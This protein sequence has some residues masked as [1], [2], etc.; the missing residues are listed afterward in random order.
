V[1]GLGLGAI[2][3]GL[4][5]ERQYK[6]D[7][8]IDN[9]LRSVLFQVPGPGV[10]DPSECLDGADLPECF[11]GVLDLGAIDIL[12]GRDHGMPTYNDMRVA[13]G[14]PPVESFTD[15]TGEDTEEFPADP[16]IDAANP[17]AD[18]DILDFVQLFDAGGNV[19][20]PGTDEAEENVVT[21]IRRTTV[22][23][24]QKAIYGDVDSLDAFVG[25]VSE[26]HVNGSEFGPLQL[27]IWKA[28]FEALRDGDRLFYAND[29]ALK[30]I[31]RLFGVTYKLSLAEVIEMNTDVEPDVLQADVFK[32][33]TTETEETADTGDE[34]APGEP[35]EP[36]PHHH[37]EGVCHSQR[38]TDRARRTRTGQMSLRACPPV[39]GC[40]E[41][42]AGMGRPQ[43]RLKPRAR[44]CLPVN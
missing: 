6:N 41:S 44:A 10:E 39:C 28:Q 2:L 30:S 14:L 16:E 25:M 8:Q 42:G 15:I 20:E 22:A 27:A 33:S 29:A 7:E 18:P 21:G 19:V 23:A 37:R 26:R 1:P 4:A 31:R 32:I 34:A 43:M 40:E 12:R 17:L 24:R 13:Y 35:C 5:G 36:W 38:Q 9:Q 11:S 3:A